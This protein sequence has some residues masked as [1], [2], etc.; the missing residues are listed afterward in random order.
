LNILFAFVVHGHD[1]K[2]ALHTSDALSKLFDRSREASAARHADLQQTVVGKPG[3]VAA[4][5]KTHV[6]LVPLTTNRRSMGSGSTLRYRPPQGKTALAHNM[7]V[8][9][10]ANMYSRTL[11]QLHSAP[12]RY[13]DVLEPD[14]LPSLYGADEDLTIVVVGASGDLARKKV[15]PAI[16][17]LYAQGLLPKNT[18]VVGYSRSQLSRD[19]FIERISEKLMCRIDWDAPDCGDDMDNFLS[20]TNYVAGGYDSEADFAKLDAFLTEKEAERKGKASNRLFY[21]SVTPAVFTDVARCI[22][23]SAS[24]HGHSWTRVVVEKPFGFDSESSQILQEGLARSLVEKQIYRIDHYLGKEVVN[25]LLVLRFANS[26]F[27]PVW[28]RNHIKCVQIIFSEDFGTE[29]RGGYF[30]KSGIIRDVMQ[31]HLL[32]VLSLVAMECP[33]SLSASDIQ[34]EKVKLLR[35]IKPLSMDDVVIGQYA[36]AGNFKGYKDDDGVPA[37]SVCP[38]AAAIAFHIENAR[39][40]GV[41]FLMKAGKA[42]DRRAAE[43]RIQFKPVAGGIFKGPQGSEEQLNELLIRIQPDEGIVFKTFNKVPGLKTKLAETNLDM[44][45]Q[46]EFADLDI[47]QAY[48]RLI[49]DAVIGDKS[50]YIR[51]DEL[52][53]AWDLF[54]PLLKD[55][56][57]GPVEPEQYSYGSHGPLGFQKLASKYG[58]HW[59]DESRSEKKKSH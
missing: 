56:E 11:T 57:N 45:Y 52:K 5:S 58:L 30:E 43:I 33:L 7:Q 46:R 8:G 21:L 49:L 54:T 29:G 35:S 50:L 17:A 42:L 59:L 25:N 14:F 10:M 22:K 47:P 53:V 34:D 24:A 3:H 19:E 12:T 6:P 15:F 27:E 26:I 4:P 16:F 9:E 48:E 39:W 18:Q 36:P 40:D 37:D 20:A 32:Q 55:L 51:D 1:K 41:P 28:S 44:S 2:S 23:H 31:N 13:A 38:T